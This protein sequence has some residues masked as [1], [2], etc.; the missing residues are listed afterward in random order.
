[1]ADGVRVYGHGG[2]ASIPAALRQPRL[3]HRRASRLE[4]R[5][6]KKRSNPAAPVPVGDRGPDRALHRRRARLPAVREAADALG[7]GAER[8][9][10]APCRCRRGADYR[11][12]RLWIARPDI[13]GNPVALDAARLSRR[14]ASPSASVFFVHPTTFLEPRAWNAPLDDRGIARAG[15]LVRPQPGERVQRRSAQIWAPQIPPGD[16]RRLP[17]QQGRM[18]AARSISPIATCSP[19][20]RSSCARRRRTGRSSSP[21]TARAACI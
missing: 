12:A 13:A 11:Q 21:R 15:G 2:A 8:A 9:T 17:H 16:V 18:P 6:A 5:V 4:A 19:P 20:M 1:M 14:R 7:D 10:S 3:H